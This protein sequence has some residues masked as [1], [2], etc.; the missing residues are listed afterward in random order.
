VNG[1]RDIVALMKDKD[2]ESSI[3]VTT[4]AGGTAVSTII[5]R[6]KAVVSTI[7]GP[8]SHIVVVARDFGVPCI[9]GAREIDIT[10]LP[11]GAQLRLSVDGTISIDSAHWSGRDPG[12]GGRDREIAHPKLSAEQFRVLRSIAFAGAVMDPSELFGV[13]HSSAPAVVDQLVTARLV[14]RGEVLMTTAAGEA[15]LSEW[16]A[17]DRAALGTAATT[18]HEQFQPL[19]ATLK[20]LASTWQSAEASDDWERRLEIVEALASL[21]DQLTELFSRYRA[22]IGRFDDYIRRL[23]QALAQVREGRTAYVASLS[24]DSY[25]TAWFQMHE[26]LLRVLDEQRES[27]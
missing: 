25:H 1:V 6:T 7:G 15:A 20:L 24:V 4:V 21:H 22:P 17:A 16:F 12:A 2:A 5:K 19:D 10:V 13:D 14:E 8:N 26:D 9:V 18:L 27:E 11:D 3:V 23:G